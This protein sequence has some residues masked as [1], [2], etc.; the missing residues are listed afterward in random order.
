MKYFNA[1][2]SINSSAMSGVMTVIPSGLFISEATFA[3]NLLK[4]TPADDVRPAVF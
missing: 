4:E 1:I 2:L 3:R